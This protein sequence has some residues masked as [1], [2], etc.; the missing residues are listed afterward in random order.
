MIKKA[1]SLEKIRNVELDL[2]KRKNCLSII[3]MKI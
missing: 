1:N 3:I 2:M